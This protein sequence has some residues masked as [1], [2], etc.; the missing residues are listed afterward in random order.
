MGAALE[1]NK[2]RKLVKMLIRMLS[3]ARKFQSGMQVAGLKPQSTAV[4][5]GL[6]GTGVSVKFA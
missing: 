4:E 3:M 6:L 5:I 2:D 1:K